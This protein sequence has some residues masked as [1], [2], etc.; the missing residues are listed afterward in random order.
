[1]R[2]SREE[3]LTDRLGDKLQSAAGESYLVMGLPAFPTTLSVCTVTP[4]PAESS[5]GCPVSLDFRI[6]VLKL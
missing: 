2:G 1:M 3:R 6:V 4:Y 5:R